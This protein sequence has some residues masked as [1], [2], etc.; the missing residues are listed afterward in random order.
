MRCLLVLFRIPFLCSATLLLSATCA[1]ADSVL[2]LKQGETVVLLGDT[3]FERDYNH[4][5]LETALTV[6]TAGKQIR[7]RNL[8]WSGDTPRG[9]SRSYFGPPA[10]GFARLKDQ[11][12]EIKPTTVIAC[13]GAVDSFQGD[14]GAESFV[15]AYRNLIKM[16]RE[17]T[18]A[19]VVLLSPPA[20]GS[21]H[22]R[23]PSL[24]DH[25]VA[26]DKYSQLI[27]TLAADEKLAFADL[28][29]LMRGQQWITVNG[30]TFT[31][32]DYVKIAPLLVKCLGLS[33][34]KSI[35]DSP[36]L[37]SLI[38]SKNRLFFE[39]WRPQNE[40]YLF[41]SRKHEQGR[42]GAEIPQFDPL[43][44]EMEKQIADAVSGSAK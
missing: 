42:N 43:I 11:L 36:R 5:S 12:K 38:L 29:G 19:T 39:R 40:I 3:F 35:A 20:T 4:G 13:Y 26:L 30:I 32:E 17:T 21:D 41:G 22:A 44:A 37:R 25:E 24:N 16:V 28:H 27:A 33:S 6:A 18:G 7:F 9:E 23:W 15:S 14:A 31:P 34:G 8:G 2:N 1:R 10:E